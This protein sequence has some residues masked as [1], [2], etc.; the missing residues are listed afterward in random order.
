MKTNKYLT[1]TLVLLT[2]FFAS[3]QNAKE[4]VQDHRQIK[5]GNAQLER[6]TNE[7]ESFKADVSEFQTALENGDTKLAQKYRKGILT[8]MEREIQQTEGKIAWAKRE[9]VQS[10]VEKG[11]NRREKRSNRRTFEGTPDDRRDM[12]R[13]RRNNR[14]DRRDKRDDVADRA[15][16][17][18]RLENQK[19]L[20]ESAKADETLGNGILEKFIATLN[21]DLLETQEELREDKGELRED[22]RERRDD[23]RERKE[24][25]L[26]G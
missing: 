18:S 14:D 25:K 3:A 10:S 13:D 4:A 22:R 7:L 21:N 26:N 17:E 9:V 24:N 19:A 8:A 2:A 20:Y 16:L 5:V 23:R 11:T 6:D 1:A 12:R 15:E